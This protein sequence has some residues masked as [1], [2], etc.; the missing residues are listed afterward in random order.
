MKNNHFPKNDGNVPSNT[1]ADRAHN[2]V[3]QDKKKIGITN[4]GGQ[5]SDQTSNKDN[6]RKRGQ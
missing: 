5:R 6:E 1:I 4:A 3:K 2:D